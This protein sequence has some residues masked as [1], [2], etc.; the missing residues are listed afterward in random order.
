M[1]L[2]CFGNDKGR[3]QR[4]CYAL[5]P[6]RLLTASYYAVGMRTVSMMYTVA[7]AV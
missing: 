4:V 5:T 3:R 2:R 6:P 7:L 1:L